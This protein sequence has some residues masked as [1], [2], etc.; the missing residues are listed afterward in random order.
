MV[1]AYGVFATG[2]FKVPLS[3]ILRIEDAKGNVIEEMNFTPKRVLEGKI[4]SL[5]TDILS[6]NEA[7]APMFGTVS[8][9]YFKDLKV[10]AKTGTTDN[11]RDGWTIGYTSSLVAGVW[12]G[13]NDNSPMTEKPAIVLAGP[14]FHQFI[15]EAQ[16]ILEISE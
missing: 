7:R 5:I 13:N 16:K 2:G 10:A 9:L 11:F 4:A 3:A 1:S 6:D 14:I 12:V 8:P 15:K